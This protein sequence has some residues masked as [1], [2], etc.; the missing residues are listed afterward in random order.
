[1][2]LL[3][4]GDGWMWI[5]RQNETVLIFQ[6]NLDLAKVGL[7]LYSEPLRWCSM[8]NVQHSVHWEFSKGERCALLWWA[9]AGSGRSWRGSWNQ[10]RA[11]DPWLAKH[12]SPQT[13]SSLLPMFVEK[14]YQTPRGHWLC[15]VYGCFNTVMAHSALAEV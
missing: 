2:A 7:H 11:I 6:I 4:G 14:L 9:D 10:D 8:L 13:K 5:L 1:M 12:N 15:I 3:R